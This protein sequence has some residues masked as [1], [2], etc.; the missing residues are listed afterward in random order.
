MRH[1]GEP[2]PLPWPEL[3]IRPG[4]GDVV[5]V[6]AGPGAGK[7]FIALNWAVHLAQKG[8]P[9]LVISTDT[10]YSD[11]AVRTC[12]LLSGKPSHVIEANREA[13]AEWLHEQAELPIRWSELPLTSDQIQDFLRAEVEF[14]GE[15]PVLVVVDVLT[16][17][18]G[19]AEENVGEVRRIVR[20]LKKAAKKFRTTVVVLHHIKRGKAA[21]GT[22]TVTLQDGLYGGEQDAQIV[23]GLWRPAEQTMTVATLKN[24]RGVANADGFL[25]ADLRADL[26]HARVVSRQVV[27]AW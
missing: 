4:P 26:A 25:N 27:Q 20:E 14:L 21:N 2:I 12:A 5:L 10:D 24:R 22:S 17:M 3:Q 19:G 15:T 13:W 18:L 1:Q 8:M 23:L 7:S 11:Q 9:V 6:T 16:D